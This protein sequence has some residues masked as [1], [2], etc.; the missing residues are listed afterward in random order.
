M[1]KRS[2]ADA[3]VAFDARLRAALKPE[4]KDAAVLLVGPEPEDESPIIFL[5]LRA[6]T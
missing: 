3:G 2:G 4:T 1:T 5:R 6:A